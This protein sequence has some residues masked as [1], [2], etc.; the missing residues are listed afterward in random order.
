MPHIAWIL[1]REA[2]RDLMDEFVET[3][4]SELFAATS[5]QVLLDWIDRSQTNWS[6]AYAALMEDGPND[7]VGSPEDSKRNSH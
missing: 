6:N 7:L 3:T 4:A 1:K 2:D 5:I